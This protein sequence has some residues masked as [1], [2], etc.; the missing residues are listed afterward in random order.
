LAGTSPLPEPTDPTG[1]TGAHSYDPGISENGVFWTTPIPE[2]S[3][4]A[5]L[6][7]GE[8]LLDATNIAVL[9]AFTIPNSF[10]HAVTPVPAVIDSLRIHWSGITRTVDF[11]SADP[12]DQFAGYFLENS[13]TIEVTATTPPSDDLHGFQFVSDPASTTISHFAQIGHEQNGAFF[14]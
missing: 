6:G 11:S 2:G 9:D 10:S 7:A 13:A 5:H 8:A 12:D 14:G 3:V 4:S 1:P